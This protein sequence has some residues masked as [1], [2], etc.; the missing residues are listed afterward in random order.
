VEALVV[1]FLVAGALVVIP[2]LALKLLCGLVFL[3]FRILGAIFSVG[4]GLLGGLLK[5]LISGVVFLGVVLVL[6]LSVVLLPLL[7]FVL[8]GGVI[9]LV[10]KAFQPRPAF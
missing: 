9:W 6:L 4:F 8:L 10:V 1:L 3:P 2:L 5:L 7:P